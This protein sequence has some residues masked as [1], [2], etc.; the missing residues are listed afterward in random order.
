MPAATAAP[1]PPLDPPA[2]VR[3]SHGLRVGPKI[4]FVV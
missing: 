4:A 3:A 2:V 1:D